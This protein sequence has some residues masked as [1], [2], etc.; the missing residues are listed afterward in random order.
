VAE[1]LGRE[2]VQQLVTI[3]RGAKPA[4]ASSQPQQGLNTDLFP[5]DE[6]L[7]PP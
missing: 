6:F 2:L 3:V 5:R 1:Y 4:A 7:T